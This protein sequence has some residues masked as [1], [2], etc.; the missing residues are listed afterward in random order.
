MRQTRGKAWHC[1]CK[2]ELAKQYGVSTGE[3]IFKAK[4]KCPH[5]VITPPHYDRYLYFSNLAKEI[6]LSFTNQIEPFGIDECWLDVTG[7]QTLFGTPYEIAETIRQQF[8]SQLG[9][10]VS[11][12][13]SFNKIFAKLASDLKKPNA[14]TVITKED[15]QETIWKLPV[16]SMLG[17]GRAT[18]KKLH[19]SGVFTI[20]ELA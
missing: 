10:T 13:V 1:A 17:V 2:N 6:Y 9:L 12:G 18:L 19:E 8:Y 15:F 20:G 16:E 7:S 4:K 3:P 14:T 11:V 5:L